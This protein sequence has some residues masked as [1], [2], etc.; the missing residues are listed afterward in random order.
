MQLGL[1]HF[2]LRTTGFRIPHSTVASTLPVGQK[3]VSVNVIVWGTIL[4][5][6]AACENFA[7]LMVCRDLL[8]CAEA[9]IVPAWVV[10]TSQWYRKEGQAFLVGIWFSMC[11]FAQMFGGYVHMESRH[12]L[13]K[14]RMLLFVVGRSSS[15]FSGS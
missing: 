10:F 1:Q 4:A 15:C 6:L 8:G 14:T 13:G 11:G 12:T 2:L 5:C 7:G 9:A 3:K